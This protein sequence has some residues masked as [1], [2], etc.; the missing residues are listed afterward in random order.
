MAANGRSAFFMLSFILLDLLVVSA[1][2][3]RSS[4]EGSSWVASRRRRMMDLFSRPTA[5]ADLHKVD[6]ANPIRPILKAIGCLLHN[7]Y[8][9][10]YHSSKKEKFEQEA[11]ERE[12][13]LVARF[14]FTDRGQCPFAGSVYSLI[15][16]RVL[17]KEKAMMQFGEAP[18]GVRVR[19]KQRMYFQIAALRDVGKHLEDLAAV[20]DQASLR[21]LARQSS[22]EM[23][24]T[25]TRTRG[26]KQ[27]ASL[28]KKDQPRSLN[29]FD[30]LGKIV[31]RLRVGGGIAAAPF[32]PWTAEYLWGLLDK[33][34]YRD[35]KDKY[36][37]GVRDCAEGDT[38][39]YRILVREFQVAYLVGVCEKVAAL[40]QSCTN[41]LVVPP[42]LAQLSEAYDWDVH[43]EIVI[44]KIHK[45]LAK[46]YD[47]ACVGFDRVDS[48]WTH[49][50][51][52]PHDNVASTLRQG[53]I[54]TG[55]SGSSATATADTSC[56]TTSDSD[57]C[58]FLQSLANVISVIKKTHRQ[59]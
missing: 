55:S 58:V 27:K 31:R 21:E 52:Y 20:I 6:H 2:A 47:N 45:A 8:D 32:H 40:Q 26:Y 54:G 13:E 16:L 51:D 11:E 41:S 50:V 35:S 24:T 15:N 30:D 42:V 49:K 10:S 5:T 46:A 3:A 1:L 59:Q 36:R 18:E 22:G 44:S 53:L 25:S 9:H 48:V 57:L 28:W 12:K 17:S 56:D 29:Y 33:S 19:F 14:F 7:R 43:P 37:N 39:A 4:S 38:S 34:P 23:T